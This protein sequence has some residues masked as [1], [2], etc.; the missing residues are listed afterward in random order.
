LVMVSESSQFPSTDTPILSY[1]I[2]ALT[3]NDLNLDE[4]ELNAL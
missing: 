1:V 2:A 3:P 4:T